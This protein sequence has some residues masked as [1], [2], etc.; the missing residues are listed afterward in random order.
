MIGSFKTMNPS[1]IHALR[2]AIAESIAH[3]SVPSVRVPDI[4]SAVRWIERNHHDV[5]WD[6]HPDRITIFGDDPFILVSDD[7]DGSEAHFVLEI[8]R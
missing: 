8:L 3:R 5:D 2:S 1:T 6:P 7:D 4:E